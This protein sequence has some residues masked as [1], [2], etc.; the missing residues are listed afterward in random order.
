MS[1]QVI[2]R[3]PESAHQLLA[4]SSRLPGVPP[5]A[6]ASAS[7]VLLLLLLPLLASPPGTLGL[8]VLL[9]LRS[10]GTE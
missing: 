1:M 2:I 5:T 8:P 6:G 7:S 3:D 9:P 10:G 4:S